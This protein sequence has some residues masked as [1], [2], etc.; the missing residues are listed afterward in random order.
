MTKH[1]IFSSLRLRQVIND[2][3][4]R[5]EDASKDLKL[6]QSSFNS[7]LKG[8]KKLDESF[9]KKAIAAWPVNINDFI[10]SNYHKSYRKVKD[11]N[12]AAFII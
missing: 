9:V 3:K 2:L 10:N 11:R 5:P 12:E 7:Y 4:R 1:N 8:K 6:S